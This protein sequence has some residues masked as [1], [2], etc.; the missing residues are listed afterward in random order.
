MNIYF[1]DN[2]DTIYKNIF[3]ELFIKGYKLFFINIDEFYKNN[4][5]YNH[6]T[7]IDLSITPKDEQCL[8]IFHFNNNI[9]LLNKIKEKISCNK[10]NLL[11]ISSNI[12]K[13]DFE[14]ISKFYPKKIFLLNTLDLSIINIKNFIFNYHP[15]PNEKRSC[16]RYDTENFDLEA[17]YKN[18]LTLKNTNGKILNISLTGIK[19]KFYRD[20]EFYDKLKEKISETK[21]FFTDEPFVSLT[22]LIYYYNKEA[23]LKFVEIKKEHFEKLLSFLKYFIFYK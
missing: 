18:P 10:Q 7:K 1:F 16:E 12:S 11:I 19:I 8:I 17:S 21:I 22:K 3:N 20:L 15:M 6:N 4:T 2:D 13:D 5:T 14:Q 9:E 23:G